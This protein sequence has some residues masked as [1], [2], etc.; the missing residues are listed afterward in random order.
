[1]LRSLKMK[2]TI[3]AILAATALAGSALA[4]TAGSPATPAP[5]A[6]PPG[7]DPNAASGMNPNDATGSA[8]PAPPNVYPAVT[9]KGK[10]TTPGSTFLPYA[11]P[12]HPEAPSGDDGGTAGKTS[13]D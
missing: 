3:L 2:I 7:I 8:A 9:G 1:M 12:A 11:V 10:S 4:Q 5:T 6:S 13:P